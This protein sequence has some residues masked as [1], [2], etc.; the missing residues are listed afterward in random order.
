[1]W[2]RMKDKIICQ[3]DIIRIFKQEA[4]SPNSIINCLLLQTWL[5]MKLV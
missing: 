5:E 3:Y 2:K 4:Y 1:M